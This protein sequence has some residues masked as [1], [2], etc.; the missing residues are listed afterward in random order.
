MLIERVKLLKPLKTK[1][2]KM[3]YE[4]IEDSENKEKEI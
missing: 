1:I 4:K 3:R 2:S